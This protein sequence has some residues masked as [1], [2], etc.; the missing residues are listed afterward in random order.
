MAGGGS[1]SIDDSL[2]V[3]PGVRARVSIDTSGGGEP[4]LRS[5]AVVSYARDLA[6]LRLPAH[7]IRSLIMN[8]RQVRLHTTHKSYFA[9][10]GANGV[11]VWPHRSHAVNAVICNR[12]R[13][14]SV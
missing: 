5:F 11:C 14:L 4:A 9:Q 8:V 7:R 10:A 12:A 6:T 1:S 2:G 3:A 13:G